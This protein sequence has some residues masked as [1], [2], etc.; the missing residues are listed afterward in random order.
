MKKGDKRRNNPGRPAEAK[1]LRF[2]AR[3]RELITDLGGT[4]KSSDIS[5]DAEIR[6]MFSTPAYLSKEVSKEM[7]RLVNLG[8]IKRLPTIGWFRIK[9]VKVWL[10]KGETD[11]DDSNT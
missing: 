1:T 9:N 7:T 2:R 3:V 5:Y 8:E 6:D 4:W 11:N 10:K